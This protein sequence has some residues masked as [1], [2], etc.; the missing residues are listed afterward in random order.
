MDT[1]HLAAR[2][3][4]EVVIKG[5][6]LFCH[7]STLCCGMSAI[8]QISSAAATLCLGKVV[9]AVPQCEKRRPRMVSSVEMKIWRCL[10]WKHFGNIWMKVGPFFCFNVPSIKCSVDVKRTGFQQWLLVFP[11]KSSPLRPPRSPVRRMVLSSQRVHSYSGA[12][13][14]KNSSSGAA[15]FKHNS[16]FSPLRSYNWIIKR[17]K[18]CDFRLVWEM[19]EWDDKM[20]PNLNLRPCAVPTLR[21]ENRGILT[22]Q[23]HS[24]C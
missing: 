15:L 13:W 9:S 18:D 10:V 1:L 23:I 14:E 8:P 4:G 5:S 3:E 12:D 20:S 24:A 16:F 22:S 21:G 17:R 2:L 11:Q 7:S 19:V 6:K